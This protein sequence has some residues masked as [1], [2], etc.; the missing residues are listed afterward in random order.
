MTVEQTYRDRSPLVA[1]QSLLSPDFQE[2]TRKGSDCWTRRR[3]DRPIYY[4]ASQ[5]RRNQSGLDILRNF[6]GVVQPGEMLVVRGPSGSACSTFLKT[7]TGE[8]HGFNLSE[9]SSVNDQ[10]IRYKQMHNDF[11]GEAIYTA[12]HRR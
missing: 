5:T 7:I 12:E 10:G 3:V 9:D 4:N 6:E 11:R 8:T 2:R 1:F